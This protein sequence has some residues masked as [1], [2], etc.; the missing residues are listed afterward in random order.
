MDRSLERWTCDDA[1]VFGASYFPSALPNADRTKR[2][3]S[4][5]NRNVKSITTIKQIKASHISETMKY[6]GRSLK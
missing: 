4:T 3:P 1:A 5:E 2:F 6:D